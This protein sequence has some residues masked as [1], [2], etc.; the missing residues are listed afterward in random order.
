[1]RTIEIKLPE[2]ITEE[3]ARLSL[4]IA[5]YRDARLS[6]GEAA[7]LAG[8]TR[9]TFLELLAARGEP[10]SNITLEDF[11]EEMKVWRSLPS[12]TARP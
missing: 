1:M 8:Y 11:Q 3:E 5:L 7:K 2:A 6:Q 10:V 9:E 12:R 4:A